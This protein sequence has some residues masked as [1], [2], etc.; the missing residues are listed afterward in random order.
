MSVDGERRDPWLG[1]QR[2]GQIDRPGRSVPLKPQMAFG[3][4]GSMSM[5]SLP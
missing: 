5:V 2:R 4:S 1:R 3:R